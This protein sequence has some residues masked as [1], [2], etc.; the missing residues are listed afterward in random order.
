VLPGHVNNNLAGQTL[1]AIWDGNLFNVTYNHNDGS[2]GV[3]RSPG[4]F[5]T[6]HIVEPAPARDNFIFL[7]WNTRA[8]GL[9]VTY[10][11]GDIVPYGT[12]SRLALFAQWEGEANTV[13]YHSN[14]GTGGPHISN[15]QF[16]TPYI[17]WTPD[18][19]FAKANHFFFGWN[20][21]ADGQGQAF[22]PGRRV[23]NDGLANQTLYA[24]WRLVPI[25]VTFEP[26][27]SNP[28]FTISVPYGNALSAAM[29]AVNPLK[30]GYIFLGWF[31]ENTDTPFDASGNATEHFTL[32]ARWQP[33]A[34]FMALNALIA[35]AASIPP[36]IYTDETF[37]ALQA[38]LLDA[39]DVAANL[40]A[41]QQVVDAARGE[42]QKALDALVE[43]IPIDTAA[44]LALI[45][46][47]EG[48]RRGNSTAESWTL[49]QNALNAARNTAADPQTQE[50]V[51]AAYNVLKNTTLVDYPPPPVNKA[52]LEAKVLSVQDMEQGG[53]NDATW[54]VFETALA[55]AQ[56]VLDHP[57]ATQAQVNT[58]LAALEAAYR[59][60][61][62]IRFFARDSIRLVRRTQNSIFA[63]AAAL[64]PDGV[65]FETNPDRIRIDPEGVITYNRAEI[66]RTTVTM[67]S[68]TT[69]YVLDSIEVNIVWSWW[70]WFLVI[71]RFGWLYM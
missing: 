53:Y 11:P 8:N 35:Q 3:E 18:V 38:E 22:A 10:Q 64:Y 50:Q 46:T 68:N 54:A 40:L 24:D 45:R 31:L 26:D 1:Y 43:H 5:G 71:F 30:S 16:G 55:A 21:Q 59:A 61:L 69:G 25:N 15:G 47:T 67:H 42:L 48:I 27:N 57:D 36:G 44:L 39:L 29:P 6:N 23:I 70:Q 63:D 66:G 12:A 65:Y 51:D 7:G 28:P 33:R 32:Y 2:G 52:D 34:N 60:L 20:T 14:G 4:Q 9:G 17:V 19:T 49:M 56:D 37:A 62:P 13:T 58:A 41:T